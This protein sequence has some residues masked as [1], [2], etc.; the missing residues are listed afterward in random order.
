MSQGGPTS[1]VS[2][3]AWNESHNK[4]CAENTE[5]KNKTFKVIVGMQIHHRTVQPWH[6]KCLIKHQTP[7]DVC[8]MNNC[9]YSTQKETLN[10]FFL[11][12]MNL[13]HCKQHHVSQKS[14]FET[15]VLDLAKKGKNLTRKVPGY[16][17]SYYP[18]KTCQIQEVQITS[19]LFRLGLVFH[20]SALLLKEFCHCLCFCHCMCIFI[21]KLNKVWLS[22][23]LFRLSLEHIR[24]G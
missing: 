12:F 17:T 9:H 15:W 5:R 3:I 7:I 2:F 19:V 6:L 13:A 8:F 22:I 21:N 24:W 14:H 1:E 20:P 16:F 11:V 18:R 10:Y 4:L 23:P